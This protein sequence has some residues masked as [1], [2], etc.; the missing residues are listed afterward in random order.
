V[1]RQKIQHTGLK[2]PGSRGFAHF[3]GGKPRLREERAQ[4]FLITH[5]KSKGIK[6]KDFSGFQIHNTSSAIWGETAILAAT[7][8]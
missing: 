8:D 6:G 1:A 7:L 3:F 2:G 4:G 5:N